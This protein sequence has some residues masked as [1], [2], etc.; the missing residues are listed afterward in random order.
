MTTPTSEKCEKSPLLFNNITFST[1]LLSHA[2]LQ[3]NI[4]TH[5]LFYNI[6]YTLFNKVPFFFFFLH[7]TNSLANKNYKLQ[8]LQSSFCKSLA[9]QHSCLK[10]EMHETK[11]SKSSNVNYQVVKGLS[12]QC[13]LWFGQVW[14]CLCTYVI[15]LFETSKHPV[16]CSKKKGKYINK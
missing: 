16:I 10:Y 6:N 1:Y 12:I 13:P 15:T 4:T 11:M 9:A 7:N 14:A 2:N 3:T 8:E 5:I